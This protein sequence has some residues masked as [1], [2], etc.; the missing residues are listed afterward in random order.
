M[1]D[2]QITL[3][4]LGHSTLAYAR[5]LELLR[6]AGVTAVADVRTSPFSRHLPQFN[7]DQLQSDLRRDGL[8]Y[9]FLGKELGG[10][11]SDSR[12]YCDG[13]VDYERVA[14]SQAFAS[15]L[16]RVMEGARKYS[17]ALMCSE[18]D[19]LDCHRCLLVARALAERGA[20]VRH[21]L[22]DGAIAVQREL[23]ALLLQ[24]E[25]LSD[26]DLFLSP[27]ESLAQAYRQ[28]ARK[29]AFAEPPDAPAAHAA[30]E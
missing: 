22:G 19:P 20:A 13:V 17:V 1:R 3:W 16:Q 14:Q 9:S 5:F 12:F 2:P 30:A 24:S 4:T 27:Q 23:E 29:V 6:G 18:R 25:K 10:R 21:I 15:G 28:R 26:G 8:A 7:R 11:P